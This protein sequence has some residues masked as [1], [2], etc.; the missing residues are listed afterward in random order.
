VYEIIMQG[1]PP[2]ALT[3]RFP[4]ITLH[5]VPPATILSR[6]LAD[7]AEVDE[8]TERLRS[9]GITPVEMRTSAGGSEFRI[10][11]RL[12]RSTLRY[13]QWPNRVEK[14]RTVV[15]VEATQRELRMILEQ[16]AASGIQIDHCIRR[17]AA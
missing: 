17:S 5:S 7:P 14:E 15:R 1:A 11:G 3:A 10:E 8:L 12:G 13:L 9:L 16:L 6:R 4:L 2:P